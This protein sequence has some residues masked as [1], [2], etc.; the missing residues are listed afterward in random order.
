MSFLFSTSSKHSTILKTHRNSQFKVIKDLQDVTPNVTPRDDYEPSINPEQA[1]SQSRKVH[2]STVVRVCLIPTRSEFSPI[3]HEVWWSK[4][5]LAAI[6]S[7]AF[8][9][10][11]QCLN[12]YSCTI[13]E[14]M[15]ILYQNDVILI[16]QDSH[17]DPTKL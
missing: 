9:E 15:L 10:V 13:K 12:T 7:E 17:T 2:F 6:N 5:E 16:N 3:K 1:K 8:F 14:A 11:V 4:D